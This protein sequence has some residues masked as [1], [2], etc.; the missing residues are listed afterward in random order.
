MQ[1]VQYGPLSVLIEA[2]AAPALTTRLMIYILHYLNDP[3]L[4]EL[5]YTV[6]SL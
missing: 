2:D 6:Y 3:K 4:W 1:L 5:W